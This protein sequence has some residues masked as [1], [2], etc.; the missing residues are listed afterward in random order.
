VHRPNDKGIVNKIII[1]RYPIVLKKKSYPRPR[2]LNGF[3][4]SMSL[5]SSVFSISSYFSE[6]EQKFSFRPAKV[7]L[8]FSTPSQDSSIPD[9]FKYLSRIASCTNYYNNPGNISLTVTSSIFLFRQQP[10]RYKFLKMWGKT[11]C[12]GVADSCLLLIP[13]S[14]WCSK[15]SDSVLKNESDT[16][17]SSSIYL[18][19]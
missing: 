12:I 9:F 14:L 1:N 16:L 11:N 2:L 17:L 13:I 7:S 15:S 5:D 6:S 3:T 8:R 19:I 4:L 10:T 18:L